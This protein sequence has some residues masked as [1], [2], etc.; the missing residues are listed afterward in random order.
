MESA[1][2]NAAI[3]K[4]ETHSVQQV[5][6]KSSNASILQCCGKTGHVKD[7]RMKSFKC[8]NCG[9]IGHLKNVCRDRPAPEQRNGKE[10]TSKYKFSCKNRKSSKVKQVREAKGAECNIDSSDESD[11]ANEISANHCVLC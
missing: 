8:F 7:C 1:N 11:S 2:K 4:G 3:I 6:Q 10:T 9:C 5:S